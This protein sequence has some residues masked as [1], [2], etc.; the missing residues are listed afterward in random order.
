MVCV[1]ESYLHISW[2]N[3]DPFP[4]LKASFGIAFHLRLVLLSYLPILLRPYLLELDSFLGAN[5]TKR[6]S[7]GLRLLMGRYIN[8][9]ITIQH[10]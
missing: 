9:P 10:N 6:A 5:R 7:M 3:L 1:C 8:T 4:L 2:L